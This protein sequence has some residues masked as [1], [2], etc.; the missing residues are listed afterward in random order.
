MEI[1]NHKKMNHNGF[2][3]WIGFIVGVVSG[4]IHYILLNIKADDWVSLSK[5]FMT[6]LICGALGWIGQKIIS[7]I[8]YSI[9]PHKK[10]IQ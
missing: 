1:L 4:G 9:F 7:A 8:Y 6:S 5:P 10:N 2:T 3:G